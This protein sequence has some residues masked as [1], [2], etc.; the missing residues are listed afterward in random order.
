MGLDGFDNSGLR[1]EGSAYLGRP[2]DSYFGCKAAFMCLLLYTWWIPRVNA[3]CFYEGGLDIWITG[4]LDI[5]DITW[6]FSI[7]AKESKALLVNGCGVEQVFTLI[8]TFRQSPTSCKRCDLFSVFS[9][10][11]M[12]QSKVLKNNFNSFQS[13][14]NSSFFENLKAS[15]QGWVL[16][17]RGILGV[18]S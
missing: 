1:R 6:L 18:Y 3:I 13:P 9:A 2:G 7:S 11:E 12:K 16:A 14:L 17:P 5:L 8:K 4:Y 10:R 15:S